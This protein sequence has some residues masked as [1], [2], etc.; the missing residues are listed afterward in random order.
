MSGNN[1]VE[2][3]VEAN[4]EVNLDEIFNGAPTASEVTVPAEGAEKKR[5]IFSK[6]NKEAD[7]SF[8]ES[9]EKPT[10]LNVETAEVKEPAEETK[11]EEVV[12]EVTAEAK[13]E[14]TDVLDSLLEEDTKEEDAPEAKQKKKETRGRKS[15]SGII[16]NFVIP[17]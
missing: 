8:T 16:T 7:M 14:A 5:S 13:Q 10:D 12:K 2:S 4:V 3:K 17:Y 6:P 1:T 11:E 9:V 15:I